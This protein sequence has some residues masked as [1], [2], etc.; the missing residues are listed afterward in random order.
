MLNHRYLYYTIS[1]KKR[2]DVRFFIVTQPWEGKLELRLG[3]GRTDGREYPSSGPSIDSYPEK[4][5][6]TVYNN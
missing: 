4:L 1:K 5:G 6:I 2:R 3:R